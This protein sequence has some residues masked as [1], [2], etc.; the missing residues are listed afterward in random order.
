MQILRSI[1]ELAK[2]PGPITLSIGVFDGVHL[3]HQVVLRSAMDDA[4]ESGATAVA[5]TFDPHPARILRPDRAPRLLTSTPHKARL[6]EQF[7]IP[8]LLIVP[9]DENFAAQPP[10]VFIRA[11]AD[12]C[13]PLRRICVGAE[14]AF[15]HNRS[16]NVGLLRELG[17]ELGFT[18]SETPA[19]HAGG[20]PVSSTRIRKAVEH[21]DLGVA[22]TLL[23]RDYT[24]FG[25]VEEG[26]HLGRKLGFPTAN[27]RAHN[28]QFPP[29]GVYAVRV[30]IDSAVFPGVAN[31]GY[32]PTVAGS[33]AERKL[34]VHVF[35]FDGDLYGRDVDVDFIS[36]LRGERKFQD[37]DALKTQITADAVKARRILQSR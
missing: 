35:D 19:V 10:G 24:V 7:G 17:E 21:G 29:D 14:W 18:V 31:I 13:N 1:A 36:F 15:G 20:M 16:G 12:A 11:L 27:L 23:G 22:H 9:F 25:T 30:Q 26:D 28:E 33:I 3:G 8:Y 4:A 2:V 6:I 5:L 34:E 37:L 32:R